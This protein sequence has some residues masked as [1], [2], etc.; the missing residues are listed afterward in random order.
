MSDDRSLMLFKNYHDMQ[1]GL[2]KLMLGMSVA[3][4]AYL[5][6]TVTFGRI[7]LNIET[8]YLA[9]TLLFALSAVLGVLR[10]E[11]TRDTA[12]DNM[13]LLEI[14]R[15]IKTATAQGVDITSMQAL[16]K[17]AVASVQSHMDR[18]Y[19]HYMLRNICMLLGL[20]SYI[21]LKVGA[22]YTIAPT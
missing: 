8:G 17:S 11:R 21:A 9:V 13:S 6:Q 10:L 20:L 4:C 7:G 18:A 14:E 3:V 2:D 19:R 1:V 22:A 5:G 15:L 16:S 12:K